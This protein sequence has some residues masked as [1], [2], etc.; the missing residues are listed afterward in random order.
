MTNL[1]Y[2][3][4]QMQG[5]ELLLSYF[6]VMEQMSE[7]KITICMSLSYTLIVFIVDIGQYM[8]NASA[9]L[10]IIFTNKRI[11]I[12]IRQGVASSLKNSPWACFSADLH[13]I[14][15]SHIFVVTSMFIFRALHWA[16]WMAVRLLLLISP[17]EG[18]FSLL[19]DFIP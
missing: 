2:M 15:Y 9:T 11:I 7:P 18:K 4:R 12:C 14:S 10:Y 16:N 1:L 19:P 5:T 17:S 13:H 8:K 6:L 3:L